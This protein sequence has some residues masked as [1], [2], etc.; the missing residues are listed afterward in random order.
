MS[1]SNSTW[2]AGTAITGFNNPVAVSIALLTPT[3]ATALVCNYGNGT[4]TPMSYANGTW[5][6]GTAIIGFNNPVAVSIALLTS[7]TATALVCNFY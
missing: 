4:V 1:Y 5:T 3:T 2:T 7:T 6:A